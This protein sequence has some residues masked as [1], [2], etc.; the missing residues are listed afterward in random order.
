MVRDEPFV[1]R[2]TALKGIRE[3]WRHARP[4]V[5]VGEFY[6]PAGLSWTIIYRGGRPTNVPLVIYFKSQTLDLRIGPDFLAI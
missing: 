3:V 4:D 1:G 2:C 5:C 6:P